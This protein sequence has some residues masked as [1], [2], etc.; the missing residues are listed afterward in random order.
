MSFFFFLPTTTL[1]EDCA[2][3]NVNYLEVKVLR[4]ICRRMQFEYNKIRFTNSHIHFTYTHICTPHAFRF[5][6]G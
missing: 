6:Q 5:F 3:H 4:A 2:V 1:R